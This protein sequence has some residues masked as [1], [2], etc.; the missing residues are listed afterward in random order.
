M[1]SGTFVFS[2]NNFNA[3]GTF[4]GLLVNF[5]KLTRHKL[6]CLSYILI[7]LLFILFGFCLCLHSLFGI[8]GND[9]W[10]FWSTF[11]A[12]WWLWTLV[13]HLFFCFWDLVGVSG[14]LIYLVFGDYFEVLDYYILSCLFEFWLF[15]K[16]YVHYIYFFCLRKKMYVRLALRT[17]SRHF[18]YQVLL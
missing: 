8:E 16:S 5:S 2:R 3:L 12:V 18:V 15:S 6:F 7:G 1:F 11:Y 10:G 14:L 17:N 13:K 4:A 9:V